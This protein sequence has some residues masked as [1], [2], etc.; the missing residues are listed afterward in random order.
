MTEGRKNDPLLLLSKRERGFLNPQQEELLVSK[1][2][3]L[4]LRDPKN[5]DRS[6]QV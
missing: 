3:E 2:D 1:I 5:A 4:L 6:Q